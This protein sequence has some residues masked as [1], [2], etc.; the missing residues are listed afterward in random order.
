MDKQDYMQRTIDLAREKMREGS[1]YWPF[2]CIIVKDGEI[3]GEGC[4]DM[5]IVNDPTAHGEVVAIRDACKRL[6]TLD[7][8]GCELYSSCEPC[9]MCVSAIWYTK[10]DKV[11]YAAVLEDTLVFGADY[12]PLQHQVSLPI[13]Q[14]STPAE[15]VL[16]SEGRKLLQEWNEL[17]AN[18]PEFE[19][20]RRA[21]HGKE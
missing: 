1:G 3:V 6:G 8:S 16:G 12:R 11:Y 13:E 19:K 10:V 2:G 9:S 17:G 14:R 18:D 7:L 5:A 20:T 15:R 21:A 4:C